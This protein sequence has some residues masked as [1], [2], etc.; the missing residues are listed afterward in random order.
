MSQAV[1]DNGSFRPAI[2]AVS[3]VGQIVKSA[4][5]QDVP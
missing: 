5:E 1:S 3:P 4:L 2:E